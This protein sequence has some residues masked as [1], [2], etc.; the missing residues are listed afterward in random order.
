MTGDC[1]RC[2]GVTSDPCVT[3]TDQS[4]QAMF[5]YIYHIELQF[6]VASEK[7]LNVPVVGSLFSCSPAYGIM[8]P[9]SRVCRDTLPD[10]L[11]RLVPSKEEFTEYTMEGGYTRVPHAQLHRMCMYAA[12]ASR[13]CMLSF[14]PQA[15]YSMA[16]HAL[17]PLLSIQLREPRLHFPS[18]T[19]SLLLLTYVHSAPQATPL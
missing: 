12:L 17:T 15:A 9:T 7:I 11:S 2:M 6:A 16:L 3:S 8:P 1:C 13:A 5:D 19:I 4:P 18:H 14:C 10:A